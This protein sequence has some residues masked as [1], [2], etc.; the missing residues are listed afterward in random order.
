MTHTLTAVIEVAE[1]WEVDA[2][3]AALTQLVQDTRPEP[4]CIRFEIR[5]S[6]EHPH[7]FTLWE[8]WTSEQA[9]QDHYAYAHT[10]KVL[11]AG[12]TRI[13]SIDAQTELVPE[14]A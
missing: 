4:G 2:V 1:G 6:V 8:I 3:K 10:R 9:L 11:D 12:M 5:Q 13:V 14:A 7:R